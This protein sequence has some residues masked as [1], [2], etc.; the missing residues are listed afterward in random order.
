MKALRKRPIHFKATAEKT[1]CGLPAKWPVLATSIP[2]LVTCSE[3]RSGSLGLKVEPV[4]VPPL[5][6]A[7]AA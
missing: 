5:E 6:G 1:T 3:C 2:R 4:T 7:C